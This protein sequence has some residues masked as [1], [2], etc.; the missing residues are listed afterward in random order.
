M[1]ERRSAVAALLALAG[2]L[3]LFV[4]LPGVAAAAT[5]RE[6]PIDTITIADVPPGGGEDC[7]EDPDAQPGVGLRECPKGFDVAALLPFAAGGVAIVLAVV[8]GWFLVMRRRL[9]RP[10]PA[11]ATVGASGAADGTNAGEWWTCRS[12]GATN[13]VGSAR[14]Y[15]CG[16]W[17][18]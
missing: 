18:R 1:P 8:V 9:A 5:H 7:V 14:C 2:A 13:M 4:A 17:Q 10:F 16:S 11:D 12:C 15:S 6:R 3:V